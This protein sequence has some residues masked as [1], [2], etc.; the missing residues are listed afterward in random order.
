MLT[1]IHLIWFVWFWFKHGPCSVAVLSWKPVGP[2][3]RHGARDLFAAWWLSMDLGRAH[4]TVGMARDVRPD[5]PGRTVDLSQLLP[6][7]ASQRGSQR[8]ASQQPQGSRDTNFP[9]DPG[10][11]QTC[12]RIHPCTGNSTSSLSRKRGREEQYEADGHRSHSETNSRRYQNISGRYGIQSRSH[13]PLEMGSSGGPH[14][15]GNG[16]KEASNLKKVVGSMDSFVWWSRGYVGRSTSC[17][18]TLDLN[19]FM[20]STGRN[21]ERQEV[22][23]VDEPE[24]LE[25]WQPDNRGSIAQAMDIASDRDRLARA[26][27]ALAGKFLAASS[28]KGQLVRRTEII[29]LAKRV[30][31][32]ENVFPLAKATVVGVAAALKSAGFLSG[33][34]YLRELK[35][36]HVEEGF[37][38]SAWLDRCFK[39]CVRALDRGKGPAKRAPEAPTAGIPVEAILMENFSK[40][41]SKWPGL[42][43]AWACAWMLREIELSKMKP[44]HIRRD[45]FKKQVSIYIPLSKTDQGGKGVK[46]TLGCC[47]SHPCI[48]QCPWWLCERIAEKIGGLGIRESTS[49]LFLSVDGKALT[50]H[51]MVD[52]WRKVT[53]M[54]VTG[55]SARRSGAMD[56]IR[57]GLRIQ[58]LAFLGRWRSNV[59]LNYAEEA[60][61]ETPANQS[62]RLPIMNLS[63]N[64]GNRPED[65]SSSSFN[66]PMTQIRDD[67]GKRSQNL[68][69]SWVASTARDKRG[70][71]AH[72]I[73]DAAWEHPMETWQTACGWRFAGSTKQFVFVP[74]PNDLKLACKK[75][76]EGHECRDKS[77]E[78]WSG[79]Q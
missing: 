55:H 42:S 70:G 67:K 22:I 13:F 4:R 49:P 50:K 58:E 45:P 35:L 65:P 26:T 28:S 36:L 54:R 12:S 6:G 37:E 73:A 23:E 78:E 64:T 61:Q 79:G 1:E 47:G 14:Y 72:K 2:S 57:R 59:V 76:A 46:R 41:S 19:M 8:G 77:M 48:P 69:E 56:Y 10:S 75:C 3:T 27:A 18:R 33:S 52:G 30:A 43:Y 71:P 38:I 68:K 62:I 17:S 25:S 63:R 21:P 7:A 53:G 34:L 16:R 31:N 66:Q 60:L 51:Q 44:S 74:K 5:A 40:K 24:L 9:R 15:L 39:Q 29:S 32:T 11:K 20:M